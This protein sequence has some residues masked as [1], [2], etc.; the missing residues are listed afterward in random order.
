MFTYETV[1][2]PEVPVNEEIE[3]IRGLESPKYRIRYVPDG[4]PASEIDMSKE[5]GK[6]K[7]QNLTNG[8]I[9][10]NSR[11]AEDGAYSKPFKGC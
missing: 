10:S 7:N 3:P 4:V 5:N 9:D 1:K 11:R 2:F 6:T 8:P